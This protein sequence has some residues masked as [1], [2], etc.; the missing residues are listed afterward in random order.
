MLV[1]LACCFLSSLSVMYSK[2]IN[3]H[4]LAGVHIDIFLKLNGC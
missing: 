4:V 2:L 1:C 3:T